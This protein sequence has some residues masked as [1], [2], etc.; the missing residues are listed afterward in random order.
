MSYKIDESSEVWKDIEGYEGLYQVSDLGRIRRILN[1]DWRKERLNHPYRYLS[2]INRSKWGYK[3]VNLTKN[4]V[5]KMY[6]VHR[7][8]ATAFVEVPT[9]YRHLIGAIRSDGLPS[10]M[11][12]HKDENPSNNRADNLEWCDCKYNSNYG[13]RNE[14]LSKIMTCHPNTSFRVEQ[15]DLQGNLIDIYDSIGE[16]SRRTGVAKVLI[17]YVAYH[18]PCTHNKGKSHYY[19]EQAGGYKWKIN[20]NNNERKNKTRTEE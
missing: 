4:N 19:M 14:R 7:L 3:A 6:S 2:L 1:N 8:V 5:A 9:K 12:N 13:T 20:R 11:I 16:A 10:L 15:Y 18:I 17:R